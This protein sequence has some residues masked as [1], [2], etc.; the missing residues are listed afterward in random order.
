MHAKEHPIYSIDLNDRQVARLKRRVQ[1]VLALSE[2]ELLAHIPDKTGFRFVGCPNCDEGAQEGQLEWSISDPHH[3]QCRYCEMVFPN[4]K[5]SEDQVLEV[6]NPVGETVRYPVWE[7]STG[8]RYHFQ[9]K[10]W[11]E[12]RVYLAAIAEG[13][14]S[15]Y[16]VTGERGYARRAA[17]ILDAFARYYPGF[18]VSYDR[19]HEQKGFVFEPPYPNNGGKWGRGVQMRC[20]QTWQWLMTQFMRV[21]NWSD[22]PIRLGWM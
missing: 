14:G 19:A 6:V 17:L 11:R 22:C 7:D 10:A 2:A 3:V 5:Y 13:L 4:E 1:P 8:Y 15:L 21:V 9:A 12:A 16:Q 20:R 18:L